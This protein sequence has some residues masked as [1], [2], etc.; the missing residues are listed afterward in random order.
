MR[1]ISGDRSQQ[2]RG[3]PRGMGLRLTAGYH[4]GVGTGG[5]DKHREASGLSPLG[6]I[7]LLA[8]TLRPQNRDYQVPN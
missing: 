5:V 4:R 1:T 8:N 2:V 6:L 7:Y 3:E